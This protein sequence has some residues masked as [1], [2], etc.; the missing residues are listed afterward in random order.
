MKINRASSTIVKIYLFEGDR[1]LVVF[2]S[3]AFGVIKGSTAAAAA[4]VVGATTWFADV[5]A[6]APA[7]APVNAPSSPSGEA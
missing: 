6:D 1:S 5:P 2:P 3:K 4:L 7:E